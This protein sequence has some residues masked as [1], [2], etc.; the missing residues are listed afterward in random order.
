M[1]ITIIL[2]I[3]L[4]TGG[5]TIISLLEESR[6]WARESEYEKATEY[7]V[8]ALEVA[9]DSENEVSQAEVLCQMASLDI[10]TWRDSQ[11]WEHAIEAE[12]L[13]R[14]LQNDTLLADALLLKGRIC[15]YAN[16]DGSTPREKEAL[17]YFHEALFLSEKASS[18]SRQVEI[19]YNISQAL[20]NENRFNE[21]LDQTVYLEAGEALQKGMVLS[22]ENGRADLF[23]KALPYK[24]RYLRQGGRLEEAIICCKDFL[25]L[26]EESNYLQRSQIYNHLSVLYALSGKLEESAEAH[27]L[28]ANTTQLY[29]RQK[30]DFLLQEME[31]SYSAGRKEQKIRQMRMG[32]WLLILIVFLLAALLSQSVWVTR[33]VQKQKSELDAVNRGKD[34]LLRFVSTSLASP[35]FGV[36]ARKTME[37]ISQLDESEARNRCLSILKDAP[38]DL[39]EE[40]ADYMI[41]LSSERKTAA[42]NIGLTPREID[43]IRCC[44]E[45]YSNSQISD[46]LHISLSTV[47]NHKQSIFFKLDV[48]ST[49]EMLSLSESLGII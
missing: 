22:Q 3:Y 38:E 29:M 1:A 15:V 5:G 23:E 12:R 41:K 48:R 17:G 36:E 27:Q 16:V 18:I 33:K 28:Y 21:P 19:Y 8:K 30:S 2:C 44:R 42:K 35:G 11:A 40:V 37:D 47:K 26:A 34:E 43:I 7:V 9:E 25:S 14:S 32:I 20:V 46:V 45:G 49:Q 6:K 39:R 24:I 4:A 10:L 13:A 31:S